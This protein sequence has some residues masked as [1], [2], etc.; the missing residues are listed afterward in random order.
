VQFLDVLIREAHPGGSRPPF[1]SDEQKREAAR[2]YK[3]EEAIPWTVLADDLAGTVHQAYGGMADPLYLID[4]SGRV[5]FYG[6]WTDPPSLKGAL[7][8][9]LARGG[10]AAPVAGGIDRVPHILASFVDG[11]RGVSRGGIGAL[12]DYE[13]GVPGSATLTFLG[14]LAKPLLAPLVLRATP[15]PLPARIA[16]AAGFGAAAGLGAAMLRRRR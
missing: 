5:A 4:A 10:S 1:T 14:H 6:M 8:E 2:T 3:R 16:V 9:L 11:W 7:D 12:L 15:L 13:L